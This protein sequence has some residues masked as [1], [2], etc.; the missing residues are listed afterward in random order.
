MDLSKNYTLGLKYTNERQVITTPPLNR[1]VNLS[2]KPNYIYMRGT[3]GPDLTPS[4][5]KMINFIRKSCF[6][7][8]TDSCRSAEFITVATTWSIPMTGTRAQCVIHVPG[9]PYASTKL[10][11]RIL[12][13][14]EPRL[15][16]VNE[17]AGLLP[18]LRELTHLV[19]IVPSCMSPSSSN[20]L[21]ITGW[22]LLGT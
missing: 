13:G 21:I 5:L 10:G 7:M 6:E 17:G 8:T 16:P 14:N 1:I 22:C 20:R 18:I 3:G 12:T 2:P 15:L 19:G 11:V 9:N 4:Q